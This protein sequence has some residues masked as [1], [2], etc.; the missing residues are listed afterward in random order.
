MVNYLDEKMD[1]VKKKLSII[2]CFYSMKL[3]IA[4]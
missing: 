2:C 3:A 4:Q 1:A